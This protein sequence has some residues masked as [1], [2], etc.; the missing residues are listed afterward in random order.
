M[1]ISSWC[2]R[3]G[4]YAPAPVQC[5]ETSLSPSSPPSL[6]ATVDAR[7]RTPVFVLTG[8]LGSGKTTLLNRLLRHPA[9]G[10]TAVIVNEL[11]DVALDH[12]LVERLQGE[13]ALLRSGCICCAVRGDFEDTLRELLARRDEGSLPP[14][15]RVVIE[16]TG[17]ADPAPLVQAV[18]THPLLASFV[19]LGAVLTMVDAVNAP[20]QLERQWEARKQAA[21]ADWLLLTK[22]DIQ[23]DTAALSGLTAGLRALNPQAELRRIE[24]HT[25][26]D[27]LLAP[28][29]VHAA[30]HDAVGLLAGR[31]MKARHG[32]VASFVLEAETPLDWPRLQAWLAELRARHGERLLR[33]KGIVRVAGEAGAGGP[34]V[35]HGVHHLF[36]PPLAAPGIDW[37]ERRSALVVI[38]RG[39]EAD[40]LRAGWAD[41]ASAPA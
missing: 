28:R 37:P 4:Y 26:L 35:L 5:P 12:L 20:V 38:V 8:F 9:F 41:C 22:T 25:P 40:A 33:L 17:L 32:E 10:D 18:D 27:A 1:R 39:L 24:A 15:A 31:P 34:L 6:F 21:L 3:G 16:T 2:C 11:G 7:A 36:H 13:V 14:F 19:H 29:T 23:S 30:V